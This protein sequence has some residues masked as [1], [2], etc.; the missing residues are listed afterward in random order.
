M[1]WTEPEDMSLLKGDRNVIID[2]RCHVTEPILTRFNFVLVACSQPARLEL[3]LLFFVF[4]S[5]SLLLSK[6]PHLALCV[7]AQSLP[8]RSGQKDDFC[9]RSVKKLYLF[10][11]RH[12]VVILNLV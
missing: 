1:V 5:D 7:Y 2:A 8:L 10:R 11:L 3:E 12:V 9:V 6:I 4:N